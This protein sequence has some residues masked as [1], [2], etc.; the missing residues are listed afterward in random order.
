MS[1]L[2]K[3]KDIA[4]ILALIFGFI[5]LHRFYLGQRGK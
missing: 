2:K 4:G 3:E 5:G 1:Q